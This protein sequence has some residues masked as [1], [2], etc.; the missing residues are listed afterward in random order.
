MKLFQ[1]RI[2]TRY[3]LAG[4]ALLHVTSPLLLWMSSYVWSC[5][6]VLA[7]SKL[8]CQK[9]LS[10]FAWC[11][12][13]VFNFLRATELATDIRTY[14]HT[15]IVKLLFLPL[16]P[17]WTS[18]PPPSQVGGAPRVAFQRPLA[19]KRI[20]IEF[21]H[22]RA[23]GREGLGEGHKVCNCRISISPGT[24]IAIDCYSNSC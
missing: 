12:S 2:A 11:V 21:R 22:P 1:S 7:R 8:Q 20:F 5:A 19:N 17:R 3:L 13:N 23:L 15:Y 4:Q 16:W 9:R 6:C 10:A 14:V 18:P 24:H